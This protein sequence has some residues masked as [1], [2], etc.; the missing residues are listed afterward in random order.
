MSTDAL[1]LCGAQKRSLHTV[2]ENLSIRHLTHELEHGSCRIQD[3]EHVGTVAEL[4]DLVKCHVMD[5]LPA[6]EQ[7]PTLEVLD[8]PLRNF[9]SVRDGLVALLGNS[10]PWILRPS[11]MRPDAGGSDELG[12]MVQVTKPCFSE[13]VRA[14]PDAPT[15]HL[16]N[17]FDQI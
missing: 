13:F 4:L 16:P 14:A 2:H 6:L 9:D 15:W 17:P 7:G 1:R 12:A 5:E 11:R 10:E 8:V 3:L